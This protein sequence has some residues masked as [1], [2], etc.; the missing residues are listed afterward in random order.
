MKS[1]EEVVACVVDYGTFLS[2][3]EKLAETMDTVYYHSPYDTEYEDVRACSTGTGL[4]RVIRLDD[5][6]DPEVLGTIDLFV[7]PDIG[8]SSLQRHLRSLGKAVWGHLGAT[9]LELYRDKFL[10]VLKEVGLPTVH[11]ERIVGV[12]ALSEYLKENEDK[13]I[14]IN[15]Y[16]AN[17]ETFFHHDYCHS[18]RRLDGLAVILGG[19]K[20]QAVFVV[21]DDIES[22]MEVGFDGWSI[23][24]RFPAHSFQ[25]YEKKNELYLGS[26]LPYAQLPE[27]IQI[28]NEAMAPVLAGY[29]YRNWWATEIRMV[30]G[31]PYFIDPTPRMP[32]QTGEHQLESIANFADIIWQ[33]ANG[34]VIQP[35]FRWKFAAEATLHYDMQ[36][37]DPVVSDEWK[38]LCVPDEVARWVKLYYY[39]KIDGV[40]QLEAKN[41]DEV[42]VVIGG[43]NSTED[44]I[45]HLMENL[46]M[47]KGLPV[48]AN[49]VGFAN[50]LASIEEGESQGIKF[51][52]EIP[53]PDIILEEAV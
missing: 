16:R 12:T 24:G 17:M 46:E 41:T 9:E 53:D 1:V 18:V 26:V 31:V 21:Q 20:E 7:F 5:F 27:G 36:S 45:R 10:E 35:K 43:G 28:V 40:H 48:H 3:A 39:C 52:G 47:L 14:K 11:S 25:G 34:I 13:W 22:D 38:T 15:R 37:K 6:L 33:G 44:A 32:G 51:G 49:L 2:I 23:D 8:F 42:G 29:G 19:M 4:D 30:E 50:L